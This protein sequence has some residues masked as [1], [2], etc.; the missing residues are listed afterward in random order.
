[1][2]VTTADKVNITEPEQKEEI[3]FPVFESEKVEQVRIY[4]TEGKPNLSV[5]N[6]LKSR[7]CRFQPATDDHKA[8]WY[9]DMEN[10]RD[11]P[12]VINK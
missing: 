4:F 9:G 8:F 7:K 1:M 11:T 12:F 6:F 10:L 2:K 3:Q 5:R